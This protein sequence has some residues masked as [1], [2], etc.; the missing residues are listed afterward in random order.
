[1]LT[2]GCVTQKRRKKEKMCAVCE[3]RWEI[4]CQ[5]V[6]SHLL[7][8]FDI[9]LRGD[10]L[11]VVSNFKY[12]GNIFTSDDCL[13]AEISHRLVS[14]GIAWHQLKAR[15][16]GCGKHLTLARKVVFFRTIVLSVLLYGCETWPAL[17]RHTQRLEVFQMNCL[18]Y[19][20]GFT[21]RDHRTNVSVRHS[22]HLPSIA[23][24]VRFRRLRWLGHVA[25][26][27]GE[28]LPVQVLF[29]QLS[30]PGVKGRPRDSWRTVVHKDLSTLKVG[31]KWHKLAQD[32]QAWRQLIA[33]VRT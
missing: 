29:G 8:T 26:M 20:C 14:A 11:E 23:S 27:P 3:T 28:R 10:S 25:R 21:W 7:G 32:R 33:T 15:K 9:K 13:E 6:H 22:C 12:L 19:L 30:G 17:E 4:S 5:L 2:Q 1:M 31:W 24:E 16:L 18:R